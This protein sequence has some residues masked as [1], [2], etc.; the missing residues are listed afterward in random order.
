[1]ITTNE[2]PDGVVPMGH[3]DCEGEIVA[4]DYQYADRNILIKRCSIHGEGYGF[5]TSINA[6]TGR[7]QSDSAVIVRVFDFTD[8]VPDG[9]S[10]ASMPAAFHK[11]VCDAIYLKDRETCAAFVL[12]DKVHTT[13]TRF[14]QGDFDIGRKARAV[15]NPVEK[16]E[17]AI[18]SLGTDERLEL[19]MKLT[20]MSREEAQDTLDARDE[21]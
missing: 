3:E 10:V 5:N 15:K 8:I 11:M 9:F 2:M 4:Y 13:Y 18:N 7:K 21:E 20:G 14:K 17:K 19:I 6:K 16:A 12:N 1:M